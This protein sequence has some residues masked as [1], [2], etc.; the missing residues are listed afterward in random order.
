MNI[1]MLAAAAAVALPMAVAGVANAADSG[2]TYTGELG[3]TRAEFQ[4]STPSVGLNTIHARLGAQ[5]N[6]NWG[7]EAE[8]ATSLG[9]DKE[10]VGGVNVDVKM[11][12]L[13]GAFVVGSYP[14]NENVSVFARV[15]VASAK[16]E[17]KSGAVSAD[18]T[19]SG[20]GIGAGV[21]WF[22]QGGANGVRVE[23]TRYDFD[24][25]GV[26]AFGVGYVRKF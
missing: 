19:N 10:N 7:V 2:V 12:Y 8:A 20:W 13:V 1:R 25:S 24:G 4:D 14:V 22:P 16:I 11:N 3:Y 9:S 15:G 6:Q 21:K 23:Y 17:A 18:D 5:F 26:N